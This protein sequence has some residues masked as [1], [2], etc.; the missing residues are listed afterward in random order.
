[1]WHGRGGVCSRE[2]QVNLPRG[3]VFHAVAEWERARLTLVSTLPQG[4]NKVPSVRWHEEQ[5]LPHQSLPFKI[6]WV[7]LYVGANCV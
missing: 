5:L 4:C 1:M 6:T 3:K 2:I 7:H